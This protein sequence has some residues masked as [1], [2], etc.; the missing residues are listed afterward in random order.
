MRKKALW[1]IGIAALV[2]VIIF[3]TRQFVI[4]N[5]HSLLTE[6][7]INKI[8]KEKYPGE[9]LSSELTN[10][11]GSKHYK[12]IVKGKN[13]TYVV[14]ADANTGEIQQLNQVEKKDPA[15]SKPEENLLTKE[16]AEKMASKDGTVKS[17]EFNKEKQLYS[18]TVENEKTQSI[19]EINARTR[20]VENK[21]EITKTEEQAEPKTQISEKEAKNIAL[22]KMNGT[23]TDIE[24]NDDDGVLVYE[25]EMETD[26]EE[27]IIFINA[28]TGEIDGTEKETKDDDDDDE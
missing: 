18:V 27:A 21:K 22:K 3:G 14:L 12:V 7:K 1:M 17:T 6:E 28:F 16:E 9:L 10:A 26:K 15:E 2:L 8:V 4:G 5:N 23:V 20:K 11:K 24:L 13:G 25:V 19:I